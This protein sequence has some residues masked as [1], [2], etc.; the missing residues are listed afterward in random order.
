MRSG[1]LTHSD[2]TFEVLSVR[3]DGAVASVVA[4]GTNHGEWN[5]QPFSAEE[6]VTEVFI[7]WDGRWRCALSALTPNLTQQRANPSPDPRDSVGER[8]RPADPARLSHNPDDPTSHAE[9]A[10]PTRRGLR[11][12]TGM[13]LVLTRRGWRAAGAG[14]RKQPDDFL[15]DQAL[16]LTL[17][18][19][20]VVLWPTIY[21]GDA[22]DALRAEGYPVAHDDVAHLT[23][24]QHDH[25]NFY[26][27][28][29]FDLETELRREGRR[30][31]RSPAA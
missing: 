2:M 30:P 3:R 20:A 25:I 19:N 23:P 24:A 16:C 1:G 13:A 26:G 7:H 31:L 9:R 8:T 4:H 27:T 11:T 12:F 6:W 10:Q 15:L 14:E 5:G 29:S 17:V 22:L 21:V 28:Y 18:T